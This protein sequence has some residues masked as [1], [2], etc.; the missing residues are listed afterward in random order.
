MLYVNSPSLN[1]LPSFT[2]ITQNTLS[3]LRPGNG[4]FT[5]FFPIDG[6]LMPLRPQETRGIDQPTLLQLVKFQELNVRSPYQGP[7]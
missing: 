3:S 5:P 4:K 6:A 2:R 1:G 7:Q